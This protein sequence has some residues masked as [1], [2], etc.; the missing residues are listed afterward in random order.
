MRR[1]EDLPLFPLGIVML[2]GETVPLHVFEER[3]REM[4]ERCVE[5]GEPFCVVLAD[6]ED[7]LRTTGCLTS[8]IEVLEQLPDGRSNIAVVG[9][10]IVEIETIDAEAHAYLSASAVVV[11]DEDSPAPPNAVDDALAAYRELA[12][13]AAVRGEAPPEPEPGP[14][15]SYAIAGRIDFGVEVKQALLEA[16]SEKVRLADITRLVRS[17][18]SQLKVANVAG[19]R[20]R[21]N[22]KVSSP[23]EILGRE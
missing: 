2:P 18:S 12:K 22:G 10:E 20:A 16:R 15:L 1:L 21:S 17:A 23:D 11:E 19:E 6:D 13:T 4:L 8:E 14:R 7:G 5:H 9:G 3:Y